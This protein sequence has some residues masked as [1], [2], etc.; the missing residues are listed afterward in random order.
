[1]GRYKNA[2]IAFDG[3]DSSKN[4]LK[5]ILKVAKKEDIRITAVTV[6]RTYD[7]EL[8]TSRHRSANDARGSAENPLSNSIK[9]V[10]EEGDEVQTMLSEGIVHE[11]IIN[12]AECRN[13][14][15]IVMGRR[16]LNRLERAFMG[17]VTAQ[18]IRYSPIDVLV[19]PKNTSLGWKHV[20]LAT[21]GSEYSNIAMERSLEIAV[22]HDAKLSTV[23]VADI[24]DKFYNEMPGSLERMNDHVHENVEAVRAKAESMDIPFAS[25][26][27]EGE[28]H[29]EIV[30]LA[31][32]LK[33]DVICMGS[34]GRTGIERI[35]MGSVAENVLQKTPCPVLIVKS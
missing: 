8:S 1:M 20:L 9:I 34:H 4:A 15:L 26:I 5:Q 3:S 30:R 31:R 33:V 18:V 7:S 24:S 21:D 19:M 23:S 10:V 16:G 25:Y 11:A 27:R 17:S 35:L 14:D 13:C 28:P 6:L 32:E 12:S 2:L 29:K 22:S